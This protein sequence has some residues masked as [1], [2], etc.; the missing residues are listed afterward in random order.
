MLGTERPHALRQI[1][2]ACRKGGRV[3]IPGVYGGFADKFPLGQTMEK[4]LT[5]KQGQTHVQ[6]YTKT[7][8][9]MIERGKIDTTFLISHHAPLEEAAEMYRHWH[10][11]QDAYTKIVLKTQAAK[12]KVGG[13]QKVAEPA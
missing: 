7:L 12:P 6:K 8:L 11:E 1:I 10:D 9:D 13:E 3:S 4:G 2:F 5:I